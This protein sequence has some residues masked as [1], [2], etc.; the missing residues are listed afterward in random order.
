MSRQHKEDKIEGEQLGTWCASSAE[1]F[2]TLS[3]ML[4]GSL[5]VE[6]TCVFPL[7]G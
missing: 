1:T 2:L 4:D 5:M 3:S 6:I 7:G